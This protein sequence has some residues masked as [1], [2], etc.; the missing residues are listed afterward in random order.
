MAATKTEPHT[1]VTLKTVSSA[2][3]M[4][5]PDPF[6]PLR[7]IVEQMVKDACEEGRKA[8]VTEGRVQGLQRAMTLLG[9]AMG[10][11][12]AEDRLKFADA[13]EAVEFELT[14]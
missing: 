7:A 3:G 14:K 1:A 11:L 5:R 12:S 13:V 9:I 2:A 8:G 4:E 6:A 10:K